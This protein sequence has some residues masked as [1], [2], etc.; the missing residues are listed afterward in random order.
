[1]LS[2][3]I[4]KILELFLMCYTWSAAGSLSYSMAR[5]QRGL[6]IRQTFRY[7][8]REYPALVDSLRKQG[9]RG[10]LLLLAISESEG[11][12]RSSQV[13][14]FR[15]SRQTITRRLEQIREILVLHANKCT[16]DIQ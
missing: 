8:Q 12:K 6:G 13:S 2:S 4:A 14:F 9:L 10:K 16:S 5:R 15:V 3:E 11:F 1:M 7:Y